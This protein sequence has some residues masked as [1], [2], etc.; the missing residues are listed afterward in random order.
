MFCLVHL[1]KLQDADT[2]ASNPPNADT[3][4]S[5]Q[6]MH[7]HLGEIFAHT[8]SVVNGIGYDMANAHGHG[9]SDNENQSGSSSKPHLSSSPFH[10][11]RA[12]TSDHME[13]DYKDH[14]HAFV[15][16]RSWRHARCD[17]VTGLAASEPH[18]LAWTVGMGMEMGLMNKYRLKHAHGHALRTLRILFHAA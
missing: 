8:V 2:A 1:P 10:G 11:R 16:S 12:A 5:L 17:G 14:T 13:L 18:V 4:H 3:K 6:N 15:M 7:K 9:P